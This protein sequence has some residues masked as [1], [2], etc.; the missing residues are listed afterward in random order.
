M[1]GWMSFWL[2]DWL[3]DWVKRWALGVGGWDCFVII[4]IGKDGLIAEHGGR[5]TK[6]VVEWEINW[7]RVMCG[8]LFYFDKPL[9][10]LRTISYSLGHAIECWNDRAETL[11]VK[12]EMDNPGTNQYI[13]LGKFHKPVILFPFKYILYSDIICRTI[14]F[15]GLQSHI[16]HGGRQQQSKIL[17]HMQVRNISN[18][19]YARWNQLYRLSELPVKLA[20]RSFN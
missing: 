13:G 1:G 7:V 17:R 8:R 12:Q 19:A 6:R 16:Q 11:I 4:S 10:Q 2:T 20:D 3:N 14:L 15:A 9:F 18:C 5:I